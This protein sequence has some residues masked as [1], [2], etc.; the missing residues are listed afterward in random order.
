MRREGAEKSEAALPAAARKDLPHGPDRPQRGTVR[1]EANASTSRLDGLQIQRAGLPFA[2]LPQII[3]DALTR[4]WARH[5]CPTGLRSFRP[6]REQP[7]ECSVPAMCLPLEAFSVVCA[8][9]QK[10]VHRRSRSPHSSAL[11]VIPRRFGNSEQARTRAHRARP[12]GFCS[13]YS[14][15]PSHCD[16]SS[17]TFSVGPR[18]WCQG[19]LELAPCLH[20]QPR[21]SGPSM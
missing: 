6:C 5:S 19:S 3:A 1:A 10:C 14:I 4:P 9:T 8:V 17:A 12:V 18:F 16:R 2:S 13:S 15:E 21:S 20:T 11:I 7:S